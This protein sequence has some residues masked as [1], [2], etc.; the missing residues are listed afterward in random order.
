MS[1]R[2]SLL[3]PL[4]HQEIIASLCLLGIAGILAVA[5]SYAAYRCRTRRYFY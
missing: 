2:E 5:V 1:T 4:S 3:A